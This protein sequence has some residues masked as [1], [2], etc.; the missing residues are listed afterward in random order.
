MKYFVY[1]VIAMMTA[2][3]QSKKNAGSPK[4]KTGPLEVVAVNYPLQ[5]FAERIGGEHVKVILPVPAD[6]DPADWRPAGEQAREF[7]AKTQ[8]ADLILLNGAG[9][10]KWIK[11]GSWSEAQLVH[12]SPVAQSGSTVPKSSGRTVWG[13]I[14]N[15][16]LD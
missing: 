9:Y 7:I 1:T 6:E 10:A 12:T 8:K 15:K 2:C 16:S 11:Y 13:V 4:I 5:F 14:S 3:G